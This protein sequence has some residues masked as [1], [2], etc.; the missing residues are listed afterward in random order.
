MWV[1]PSHGRVRKLGELI[2]S[3]GEQDRAEP[4][5]VVVCTMDPALPEYERM[6]LPSGWVLLIADGEYSYCGEKMNYAF[7]RLP[8]APFYGH[9]C[10][11]VL[12][13]EPDRLP[14][15][16]AAAGEWYMSY[17][18]DGLHRNS[19]VCFPCTG[20][21]LLRTVGWWAHPALKH[22]CLD[23]VLDDIGRSSKLLKPRMDIRFVVKH[24]SFGTAPMDDTYRRV[25]EINLNAGDVYH[26]EWHSSP[27]RPQILERVRKG[28][29][30][31][32][33]NH[34]E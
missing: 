2:E 21:E 5:T 34:R 1:I 32:F 4:F 24:P 23:S 8:Q 27:M 22:N 18:D 29:E 11:D 25:E 10:D 6:T 26:K 31:Y 14:E 19:L 20:G 12:M 13:A 7:E 9:L 30:Q 28:F 33:K 16:R 17:P 15:L 3:M